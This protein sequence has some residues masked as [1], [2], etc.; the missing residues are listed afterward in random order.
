[1]ESSNPYERSTSVRDLKLTE[2]KD[3]TKRTVTKP[4]IMYAFNN[5]TQNARAAAVKMGGFK[6]VKTFMI[7]IGCIGYCM[8]WNGH[9]CASLSSLASTTKDRKPTKP[10]T[11]SAAAVTEIRA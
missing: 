5:F 3:Y 11:E 7:G 1:M 4:A 6:P 2:L 9:L 10:S 8:D